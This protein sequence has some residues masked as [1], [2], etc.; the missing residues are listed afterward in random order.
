M[1][2][3]Q[4]DDKLNALMTPENNLSNK[5][6]LLTYGYYKNWGRKN[7]NTNRVNPF[8]FEFLNNDVAV[9]L[10]FKDVADAVSIA[11]IG[12]E[13]IYFE[14]DTF[15]NNRVI[16]NNFKRVK[17]IVEKIVVQL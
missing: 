17:E 5:K 3:N 4:T 14:D 8:V 13:I 6:V 15:Q 10:K 2:E 16:N 12:G 9:Q 11:S 1:C 7:S